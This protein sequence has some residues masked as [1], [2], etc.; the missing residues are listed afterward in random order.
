MIVL[1]C[2]MGGEYSMGQKEPMTISLNPD[3]K[4]LLKNQAKEKNLSVS[5]Y[6]ERI[7]LERETIRKYKETSQNVDGGKASP[8]P[9]R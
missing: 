6:I 7:V 1:Y 2:F 4:E 9:K 3:A 5:E 8:H